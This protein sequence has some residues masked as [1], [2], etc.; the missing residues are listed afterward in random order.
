M[1]LRYSSFFW[2][3]E[4]LMGCLEGCEGIHVSFPIDVSSIGTDLS[5]YGYRHYRVMVLELNGK[6]V[7]QR[8]DLEQPVSTN[9]CYIFSPTTLI[10]SK[11]S[12]YLCHFLRT[13]LGCCVCS[14]IMGFGNFCSTSLSLWHECRLDQL[15]HL[16]K[17]SGGCMQLVR[18]EAMASVNTC[19]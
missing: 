15:H 6:Y 2:F 14:L 16:P 4:F 18:F 17:C 13:L 19:P 12:P 1:W 11:V 3:W 7:G 10:I 8:V 5:L 9:Y